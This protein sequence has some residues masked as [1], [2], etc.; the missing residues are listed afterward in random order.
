MVSLPAAPSGV[1]PQSPRCRPTRPRFI[2]SL[3]DA[4]PAPT[5]G[6]RLMNFSTRLRRSHACR[7]LF[8]ALALGGALAG[9]MCAPPSVHG[10]PTYSLEDCLDLAARQN[11]DVIIAGKR[12]DAAHALVIQARSGVF[13]A[14]TSTAYYQ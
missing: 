8:G 2:F 9:G 11:P 10:A 12:V 13:P 3:A 7:R 14:L 4:F 1:N 6:G 5:S